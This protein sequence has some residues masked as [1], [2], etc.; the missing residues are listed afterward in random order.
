MEEVVIK[1]CS[2]NDPAVKAAD[3]RIERVRSEKAFQVTLLTLEELRCLSS[4]I[5]GGT[6]TKKHLSTVIKKWLEMEGT[7]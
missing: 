3:D 5:E 2:I 7:E 6:F 4:Y 1:L